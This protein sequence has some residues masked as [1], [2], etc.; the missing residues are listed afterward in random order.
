[1]ITLHKQV[2]KLLASFSSVAIMTGC[3]NLAPIQEFGKNASVVA[4]YSSVAK[5]Y[6]LILERQRLDGDTGPGVSPEQIT[7]RQKDAKK[8]LDA[9][10]V[11]QSYAEALGALAADDLVSYDKEIDNLTKSL[12]DGNF[13]TADQTASYAK[14]AKFGSRMLTDF[15]RRAKLKK[16]VTTYNSSVQASVAQLAKVIESGYLT[17]AS[18]EHQ[19]FTQL[20]VNNAVKSS[21]KLKG[22][23]GSQLTGVPELLKVLANEHENSLADKET[24]ARALADGIRKFGKGHQDLADSINSASFKETV[25]LAGKYADELSAVIKSLNKH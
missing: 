17:A 21:E 20:V 2:I 1:M 7:E 3:T 13:A 15:Y 25:A 5:D 22:V 14:A 16:L 18:A 19:A 11:L 12:A 8:L 10:K 23:D 6:P 4:G 24:D 9:Q